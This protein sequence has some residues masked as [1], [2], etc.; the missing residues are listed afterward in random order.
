MLRGLMLCVLQ[1]SVGGVLVGSSCRQLL[2]FRRRQD[3]VGCIGHIEFLC[4]QSMA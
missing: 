1:C 4:K 3:C 2:I